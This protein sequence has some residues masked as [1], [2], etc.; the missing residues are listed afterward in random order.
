MKKT[1]LYPGLA[2]ISGRPLENLPSR[3]IGKTLDNAYMVSHVQLYPNRG[4]KI[5]G[6]KGLKAAFLAY[7]MQQKKNVKDPVEIHNIKQRDG[8][9][10]EEFMEHFK[11]ESGRMKGAPECM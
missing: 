6:Y 5:D 11:I 2:R 8:E 9:T 3:D 1:W 7:F 10:I 4:R